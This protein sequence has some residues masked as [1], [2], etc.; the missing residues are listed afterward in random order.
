[1]TLLRVN[2]GQKSFYEIGFLEG[3][4]EACFL[5]DEGDIR[6]I[7]SQIVTINLYPGANPIKLFTALI[8]GF[9]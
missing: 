3:Y 2:H 4:K 9:S 1:M 8:Y 5:S 7:Q 6:I